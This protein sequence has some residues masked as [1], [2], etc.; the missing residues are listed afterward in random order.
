MQAKTKEFFI[1]FNKGSIISVVEAL[2][3]FY[4]DYKFW[5][6]YTRT[7]NWVKK[8]DIEFVIELEDNLFEWK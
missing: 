7:I 6:P 1:G 5:N 2:A 3:P 8:E 4:G